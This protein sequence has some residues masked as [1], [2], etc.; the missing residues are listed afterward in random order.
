[1]SH[2]LSKQEIIAEEVKRYHVFAF[3]GMVL[4]VITGFELVLIFLPF[5]FATI[6]T[7][8]VIISLAKFLFVIFWYMHLIYDKPL[9]TLLFASGM[10]LATGTL[11]ALMLLM[12]PDDVDPEAFAGLID[13]IRAVCCDCAHA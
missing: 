1:M 4:C 11:I 6:M 13:P 3:L 2:A 10:L 9:L 8:L 7:I 5:S 12:S